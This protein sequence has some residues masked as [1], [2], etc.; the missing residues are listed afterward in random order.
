MTIVVEYRPTLEECDRLAREYAD[1]AERFW[2]LGHQDASDVCRV[3]A[4]RYRQ[5]AEQLRLAATRQAG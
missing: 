4:E 2:W 5:R 1:K 3:A